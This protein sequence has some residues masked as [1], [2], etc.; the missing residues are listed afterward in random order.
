MVQEEKNKI[1][2]LNRFVIIL[3]RIYQA[4]TKLKKPKC[5]HF[6]SCSN[7]GILA[8]KKYGL[9]LA[10]KRTINRIRDCHPFSNRNYV[11]YP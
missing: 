11:D 8:Y 7:Y 4:V 2:I 1:P 5:L 6:P 10:T 3:I 9:Y